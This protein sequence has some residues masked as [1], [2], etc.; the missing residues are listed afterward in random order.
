MTTQLK[1][2]P[3]C[4]G[5]A[6]MMQW[7]NRPMF[8]AECITLE[9]LISGKVF[10]TP[11]AAANWWNTRHEP[12]PSTWTQETPTVDG[13]Y[14]VLEDGEKDMIEAFWHAG[15]RRLVAFRFGSKRW[16]EL[17]E[18]DWF[19]KVAD[20]PPVPSA[21]GSATSTDRT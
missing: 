21:D 16:R 5:E 10:D 8:S 18:F 14:W 11:E 12:Q 4:G 2:C 19:C 6:E 3:R 9:C 15:L 13:F 7:L 1:P 20:A 17:S